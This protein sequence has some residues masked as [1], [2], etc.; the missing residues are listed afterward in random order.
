MTIDPWT[1]CPIPA[2]SCN[3]AY[4]GNGSVGGQTAD[5]GASTISAKFT[6]LID[7]SFP[8]ISAQPPLLIPKV[9]NTK[10]EAFM[11]GK[12]NMKLHCEEI[13]SNPSKKGWER[14]ERG[15]LYSTQNIVK[16]DPGRAR[17][18]SLATARANF[19]KPGAHNKGD[20]CIPLTLFDVLGWDLLLPMGCV[21]LSN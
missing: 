4:F 16:K 11:W 10:S 5:D 3:G 19:T 12:I 20:L 2:H 7:S 18:N 9:G 13:P 8:T 15:L 6:W 21:K 17:Q 14:T 1:L